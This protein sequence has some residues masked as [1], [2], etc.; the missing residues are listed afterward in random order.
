A[1]ALGLDLS[2]Q[3]VA[4]L[5][6]VCG[7]NWSVFL[8]FS[9]GRGI[10]TLGGV[11]LVLATRETVVFAC[12]ALLGLVLKAAPVGVILGVAA[13]PVS[14]VLFREPAEFSAG[15]LALFF[16]VLVKRLLPKRKW[17]AQNWGRVMCYRALFDRDI[18]DRK[19]WIGAN[20]QHTAGRRD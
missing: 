11:I 4:G 3:V 1:K 8:K 17:P 7:H 16:V 9:G 12:F 10:A 20:R 5:A 2:G 14:A 6:V 19:T 18:R 13:L 15:M